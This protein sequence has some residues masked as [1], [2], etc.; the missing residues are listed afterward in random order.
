MKKKI[1]MIATI[2][3]MMLLT[4]C[5]NQFSNAS[6]VVIPQVNCGDDFITLEVTLTLNVDNTTSDSDK[7]Y[8]MGVIYTQNEES[9]VYL[10]NLVGYKEDTEFINLDNLKSHLNSKNISVVES[11][12]PIPTYPTDMES[13]EYT[14]KLDKSEL[15][16]GNLAIRAFVIGCDENASDL[17]SDLPFDLKREGTYFG[18]ANDF[19][20]LDVTN[21]VHDEE[22]V[23]TE[24]KDAT[25]DENGNIEYYSCNSCKKYFLDADGTRETTLEAVTLP[26]LVK[27]IIIAGGD[28]NYQIESNDTVTITASGDLANLKEIQ[29]DGKKVDE[30]NYT[31]QSESITITF[32]ATYLDT[33]SAGNHTVAFVYNDGQIAETALTIVAKDAGEDAETGIGGDTGTDNGT[34][35]NGTTG[36]GITGNTSTGVNAGDHTNILGLFA[37]LGISIAGGYFSLRTKEN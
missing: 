19:L 36:A 25:I 31:K 2:G 32:N 35:I 23:K 22:L 18:E 5:Q 15:S 33:L 30:T 10:E 29:V 34:G 27:P 13:I 16:V 28:P 9:I 17:P 8:N 26:K 14:V 6:I 11:T 7:I 12:T 37:L 20:K 1:L 3:C 21:P 24:A 4:A